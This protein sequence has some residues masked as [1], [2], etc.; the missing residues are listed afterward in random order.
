[1]ARAIAARRHVLAEG[2]VRAVEMLDFA[3]AGFLA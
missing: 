2:F 3:E 1:M